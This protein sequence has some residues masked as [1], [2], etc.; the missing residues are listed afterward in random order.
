MALLVLLPCFCGAPPSYRVPLPTHSSPNTHA[1]TLSGYSHPQRSLGAV[2]PWL[3]RHRG[4]LPTHRMWRPQSAIFIRL[5]KVR[6]YFLGCSLKTDNRFSSRKLPGKLSSIYFKTMPLKFQFL[7]SWKVTFL[8][9]QVIPL[10]QL[11]PWGHNMRYFVRLGNTHQEY[12]W[13]Q[14]H[15]CS[16]FR[17]M[18]NMVPKKI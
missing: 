5:L 8:A 11:C 4:T 12:E 10:F 15:N 3:R 1:L 2:R 13:C 14:A 9:L 16:H 18:R 6:E 7:K 17:A